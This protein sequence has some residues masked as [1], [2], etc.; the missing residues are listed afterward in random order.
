MKQGLVKAFTAYASPDVRLYRAE[1][2]TVHWQRISAELWKRQVRLSG[3]LWAAL[4]RRRPILVT[5]TVYEA[6]NERGSYVRIWKK[7]KRS[8]AHRD[9]RHQ[10]ALECVLSGLRAG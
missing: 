3:L 1:S 5:L 10:Q 8:V 7:R 4:F 9:G 2:T 6:A